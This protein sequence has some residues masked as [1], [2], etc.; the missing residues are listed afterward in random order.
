MPMFYEMYIEWLH[1][2]VY[3]YICYDKRLKKMGVVSF[4]RKRR[5]KRIWFSPTEEEYIHRNKI[6]LKRIRFS[7]TEEE[8]IRTEI[9]MNEKY[10]H[11]W[12]D[13]RSPNPINPHAQ[14]TT[15]QGL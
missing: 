4:P 8:Y 14:G 1:E 15:T 13:G 12:D 5:I 9:H 3:V 7:S 2:Y 11:G 10:D 6:R